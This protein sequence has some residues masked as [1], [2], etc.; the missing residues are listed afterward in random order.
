M[1]SDY[2]ERSRHW[3]EQ[4]DEESYLIQLAMVPFEE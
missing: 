4:L 3:Q 2:S 1:P